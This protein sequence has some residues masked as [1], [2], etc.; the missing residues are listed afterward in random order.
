MILPLDPEGEPDPFEPPAVELTFELTHMEPPLATLIV[1]PDGIVS[2]L[3]I[4]GL[5]RLLPD[6]SEGAVV[7]FVAASSNGTN[8][9]TPLGIVKL[10]CPFEP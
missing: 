5:V 6:S 8:K 7:L 4:V 9:V 1:V 3:N 2:V 10:V